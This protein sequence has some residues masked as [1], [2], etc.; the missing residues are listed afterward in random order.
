MESIGLSGEINTSTFETHAQQAQASLRGRLEIVRLVGNPSTEPITE[1]PRILLHLLLDISFTD[2][3]WIVEQLNPGAKIPPSAQSTHLWA[4]VLDAMKIDDETRKV[5]MSHIFTSALS[6]M[7]DR[8]AAERRRQQ[9]ITEVHNTSVEL[10]RRPR[11]TSL[12]HVFGS[13]SARTGFGSVLGAARGPAGYFG[14]TVG[15][16]LLGPANRN[17]ADGSTPTDNN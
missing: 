14:H 3:V 7:D 13:A 11:P 6:N 8:H 1:L 10:I 12:R 9:L 5:Y 4:M 2:L 16:D 15:D 17:D